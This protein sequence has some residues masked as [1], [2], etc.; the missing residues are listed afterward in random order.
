[1]KN[2]KKILIVDDE[3]INLDYLEMML[4]KNGF[5]VEKACDGKEALEKVKLFMPDLILLDII[6][7]KM[8]G[9]GVVKALKDDPKYRDIPVIICSA[10]DDI[11][12][13]DERFRL[14]IK[15]Y[16]TKPFRFKT[17]LEQ[18]RKALK[19]NSGNRIGGKR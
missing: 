6:M 18:I 8:S 7:P 19:D 12:E 5:S 9:S 14:G 4:S 17:V 16:I 1:M 2:L 11:K 13:K 15:E 10:V 3:T